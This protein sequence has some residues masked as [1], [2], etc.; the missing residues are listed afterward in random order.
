MGAVSR[1]LRIP[2]KGKSTSGSRAVAKR[3]MQSLTHQMA[4]RE[5]TAA[6]RLAGPLSGSTGKTRRAAKTRMPNQNPIRFA[7]PPVRFSTAMVLPGFFSGS[8]S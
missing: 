6:I 5:A 4:M 7:V 3:G 8:T 1:P 2:R